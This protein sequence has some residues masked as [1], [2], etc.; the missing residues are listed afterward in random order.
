MRRTIEVKRSEIDEK[1][2]FYGDC[3]A[4]RSVLDETEV[5]DLSG[6]TIPF[7]K[8]KSSGKKKASRRR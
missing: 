2:E 3:V 8:E 4:S 5:W 1:L 6:E 7:E